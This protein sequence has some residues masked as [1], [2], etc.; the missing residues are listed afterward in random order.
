MLIS[1]RVRERGASARRG[2]AEG[3]AGGRAGAKCLGCVLTSCLA[4][5]HR[6]QPPASVPWCYLRFTQLETVAPKYGSRSIVGVVR[7]ANTT[8]S[9]YCSRLNEPQ[10][11]SRWWS[12]SRMC[13]ITADRVGRVPTDLAR[14]SRSLPSF[15]F[16]GSKGSSSR[17][18]QLYPIAQMNG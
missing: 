6:Q 7:Q 18:P 2:R 15:K 8:C 5:M 11:S 10:G 16:Q 14:Q 4:S 9:R 1:D 13:Q 12:S 3:R 17:L